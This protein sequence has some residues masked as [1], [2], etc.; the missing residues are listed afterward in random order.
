MRATDRPFKPRKYT[1]NLCVLDRERVSV[2]M[3]ER[4]RERY[5]QTDSLSL[6]KT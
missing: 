5:R 3:C 4:E 1:N 2:C 6:A